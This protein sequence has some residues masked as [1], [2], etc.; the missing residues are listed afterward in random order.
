[1]RLLSVG[2]GSFSTESSDSVYELM[3]ASTPKATKSRNVAICRDGPRG[4]MVIA[5]EH[6]ELHAVIPAAQPAAIL[7]RIVRSLRHVGKGPANP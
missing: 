4:D 3:S 2:F 7:V 1:M 6:T 5:G